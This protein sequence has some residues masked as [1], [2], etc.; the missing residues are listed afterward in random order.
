MRRTVRGVA[1]C[2]LPVLTGLWVATT[3]FGGRFVPWRPDMVDLEVYREA[4]RVLLSGGDFY[5][6]P[7][8][9]Q[10]LYPP[11]AAVLSVPLA[12]LPTVLVQVLWTVAG[13]LALLAVL[14]RVGL[15]GWV[16]SLVG[17][18]TLFLEPVRQTLGFGQLGI[19]L[20]ALVVLDLVPGPRVLPRRLLPEGFWTALAACIKLTPALFVVYLALVRRTRAFVV[21]VVSAVALTLVAAVFSPRQS[22]EF[23]TRLAHGDT[24]LGGSIVYFT[25][26]SVLADVIRALGFSA[27]ATLLGLAL[28][29]AVAALGTWAA[30]LWHRREEVALA[31]MLGG[32]AT[33]LASPV[34]WLHHFV[35][36]VPLA[37][38]LVRD[39]LPLGEPPR[40]P[41]WFA[42]LGLLF[43]GWVAVEPFQNLPN[44]GDVEL[45]WNAGRNLLASG[46]LLG[47]VAFLVAAVLVALRRP[48]DPV[49]S[50]RCA[51]RGS[52]RA[53]HRRLR[54]RGS[55]V[56]VLPAP[57]ADRT[58]I[59][60]LAW[61][62][63]LVLGVAAYLLVLRT[64]VATEN[65]NFVP[66]L[67]LLGSAVVPGT[68]LTFA[69]TGGRR[70]VV[71]SGLLALVAVLGG[72]IGTVAAGTLEYDTLRGL[73]ALPMLF[74]G[75]I[76]ETAKLIVPL[77]VLLLTR[78]RGAAAGVVVGVASGMGFATL[79][80]M[81][82]G[83][84]ALLK[85]GS[86]AA[87]DSTL[88]LRALLSPAGHVAWTGMTAAALFAIAT[89]TVQGRAFFRFLATF[90]GA[91]LLHAAWDGSHVLAVH[92]LVAVVSIVGL[93]VVIHRS[94]RVPRVC[95][96]RLRTRAR[97]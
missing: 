4:A 53:R 54:T 5:A 34:S 76:E 2:L 46:T 26:Q 11:L 79:E 95:G 64:A 92:V 94:R 41:T 60:R 56:T 66:S 9:L 87:L 96:S 70:I 63:V 59:H 97:R 30:V 15:H 90:V 40:L 22:Y 17:T 78:Y 18:A 36:V 81:G 19:F 84:T 86:L 75:L 35:W 58:R 74:V 67:L 33:L 73:G 80:T 45:T 93:L 27:G 77:L 29:A 25:N 47:G 43:C 85:S 44:S 72:I 65:V 69:A 52:W 57:E 62:A 23:W 12:L 32:V 37:V 83:F 1:V 42:V 71:S 21:A 16:L 13:V 49:S 39:L 91:V 89:S 55:S 6:L 48:V 50:S 7:G 28:S 51:G 68:V 38:V 10:F 8:R 61:I 20:V 24:G 3:E 31:V 88:L 14:H 82:Y